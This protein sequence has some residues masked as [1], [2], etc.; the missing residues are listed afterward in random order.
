MAIAR[1]EPPLTYDQY[2]TLLLAAATTHDAAYGLTRRN[3]DRRRANMH[4][5]HHSEGQREYDDGFDMII[6]IS[7]STQIW[8][9]KS[10]RPNKMDMCPFA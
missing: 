9:T 6:R 4:G 2:L 3:N 10:I 8:A 5:I 1:G 7:V